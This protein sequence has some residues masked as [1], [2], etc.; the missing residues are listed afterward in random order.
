MNYQRIHDKII[1]RAQ[2]RLFEGYTEKHHIVPKCMRGTNSK[3]NLVRL[4]AREHFVVHQLLVKMYPEHQGLV[5]S[6][7]MMT[8]DRDGYRVNN[9]MYEWLSMRYAKTCSDRM[10]GKKLSDETRRK[11]SLAKSKE[12]HPMFGKTGENNQ[13]F[14]KKHSEETRRKM[15]IAHSGKH[16]SEEAKNIIYL[17]KHHTSKSNEKIVNLI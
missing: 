3:E 9:R 8:V 14:G 2:N 6:A 13:N 12:N 16:H 10:R 7:K 4:T 11:M 1:E 17:E 5:L 15:S